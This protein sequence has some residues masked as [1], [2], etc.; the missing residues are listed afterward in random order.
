M[1]SA[2]GA[3]LPACFVL[4]CAPPSRS[5][6]H[7][8]RWQPHMKRHIKTNYVVNVCGRQCPMKMYGRTKHSAFAGGAS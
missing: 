7:R 1:I 3:P 5:A 6:E 8:L 4:A 2:T